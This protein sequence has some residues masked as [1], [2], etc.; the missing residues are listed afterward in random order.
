MHRHHYYVDKESKKGKQTVGFNILNL[1][2][3]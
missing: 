1:K 2:Y 3:Y